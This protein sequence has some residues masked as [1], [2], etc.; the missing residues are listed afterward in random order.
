MENSYSIEQLIGQLEDLLNEATRVPFGKRSMVD[1]DK[2]N[3]VLQDMRMTMPM[4]IQQA[5]KVVL[6]KN[7]IINNAK[8]EAE[9]IIRQAEQLRAQML[10]ESDLVQEA[11]RRA[12]EL[13]SAEQTR[14]ADI[15]NST[16]IYVENML[17]RVTELMSSG[18]TDL[19]T[20]LA[21]IS[22]QSTPQRQA[23]GS[24]PSH[25]SQQ[26]TV[27]IMEKPIE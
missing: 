15:R 9:N 5:Q 22:A 11:R 26:S 14:C 8:K 10:N 6:D 7:N 24:Q 2:M 4:E 17:K 18:L 12:T 19:N 20:L 3:E 16:N 23:I 25:G 13:L 21:N 27:R 1:V